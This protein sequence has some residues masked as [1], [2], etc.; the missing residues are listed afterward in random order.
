MQFFDR[1]FYTWQRM[2]TGNDASS[3]WH[4][5]SS[6]KTAG[7]I[8]HEVTGRPGETEINRRVPLF[9]APALCLAW[10]KA[11]RD[12][13]YP[14][15]MKTFARKEMLLHEIKV[16]LLSLFSSNIFFF[17]L[18]TLKTFVKKI[19]FISGNFH[20]LSEITFECVVINLHLLVEIS[21]NK[22]IRQNYKNRRFI[23]VLCA[24]FV[25]VVRI[26]FLRR[27]FLAAKMPRAS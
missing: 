19:L 5:S 23:S 11:A 26:R 25:K 9:S 22:R 17:N 24:N 14:V 7:R 8:L 10:Q 15:F 27:C 20:D 2:A 3:I 1:K 16:F 13:A 6:P 21:R 18:A 4:A 12:V